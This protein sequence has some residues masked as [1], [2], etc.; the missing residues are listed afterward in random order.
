MK[1]T[2]FIS[3]RWFLSTSWCCHCQMNSVKPFMSIGW[4]S[5][6]FYWHVTF[7]SDKKLMGTHQ[8]L[9]QISTFLDA[10]PLIGSSV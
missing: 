8:Q 7:G 6:Y 1:Q 10:E 5:Y 2:E 4:A 3:R 9:I